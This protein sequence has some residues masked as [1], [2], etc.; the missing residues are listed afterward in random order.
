MKPLPLLMRRAEHNGGKVLI[1][2]DNNVYVVVGEVG[3][4]RT[5]SQN[6]FDGGEL[7]TDLE[8]SLRISQDGRDRL[9]PTTLFLV[10]DYR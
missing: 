6:V 9:T 2:P 10:K 4:H 8:A 1:G 5:Q 3:G 7:Q